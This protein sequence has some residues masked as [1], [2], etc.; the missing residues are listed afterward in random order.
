M[1]MPVRR[2]TSSRR[3]SAAQRLS[4]HNK[5]RADWWSM[6]GNLGPELPAAQG[7]F[8]GCFSDLFRDISQTFGYFSYLLRDARF[9]WGHLQ[10]LAVLRTELQSVRALQ[11]FHLANVF[12]E[13][14]LAHHL[15]L[16]LC[17]ELL[18][19]VLT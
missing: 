7:C 19:L 9:T 8:A 5:A 18:T 17:E 2:K 3:I 11:T 16:G 15:A 4:L 1:L 13:V 10:C 12:H 14:K 6:A